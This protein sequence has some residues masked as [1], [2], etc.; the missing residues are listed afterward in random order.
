MVSPL[1]GLS[2]N[3]VDLD[4]WVKNGTEN[5]PAGPTMEF[6]LVYPNSSVITDL[7]DM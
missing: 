5:D 2:V 4:I 3:D 6:R 1:Q 7:T